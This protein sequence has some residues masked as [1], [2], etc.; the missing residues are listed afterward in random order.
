LK[1]FMVKY[2]GIIASLALLVTTTNVHT[3]CMFV[4]HQPKLPEGAKKLSR[5]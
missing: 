1:K 2:A 4:M 3:N 5:I